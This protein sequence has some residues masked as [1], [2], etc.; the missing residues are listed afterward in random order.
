MAKIKLTP[1]RTTVRV[2]PSATPTVPPEVLREA[3][4]AEPAPAPWWR[5]LFCRIGRL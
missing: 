5:R 1:P 4:G 3:L 2:K